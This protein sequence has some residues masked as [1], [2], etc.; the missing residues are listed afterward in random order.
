MACMLHGSSARVASVADRCALMSTLM[1]TLMSNQPSNVSDVR[2]LQPFTSTAKLLLRLDGSVISKGGQYVTGSRPQGAPSPCCTLC[3]GPAVSSQAAQQRHG[4]QAHGRV[5]RGSVRA[6]Q[7]P[8]AWPI[9]Q[10]QLAL[11]PCRAALRRAVRVQV[12]VPM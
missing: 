7:S 10:P 1:S 2:H 6:T 11:R 3:Q 12:R 4:M 8:T 9:A 5:L